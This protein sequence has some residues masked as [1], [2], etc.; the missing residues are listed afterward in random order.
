MKALMLRR[1]KKLK[2]KKI[3]KIIFII[4]IVFIISTVLLNVANYV[5]PF[6]Y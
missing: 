1:E 4:L 2:Q 6:F 3:K 5:V